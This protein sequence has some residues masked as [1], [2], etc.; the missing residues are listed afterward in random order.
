MNW[1]SLYLLSFLL[2]LTSCGS[3][4]SPLTVQ[5]DF[6][7]RQRLASFHV[8]TPDPLLVNPLVGQ[9]VLIQW[10]LPPEWLEHE[11]LHLEFTIRFG[12][13][14]QLLKKVRVDCAKGLY[15]YVLADDEFCQ[16]EGI[17]SYKVDLVHDDCILVAWRHQLWVELIDIQI[18]E[19]D[20]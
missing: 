7:R 4:S 1:K 18:E 16:K 14:T 19:T 6:L 12:N 5:T 17:V 13:R 11:D 10:N 20:E 8:R 15:V 2:L 3:L 9:R